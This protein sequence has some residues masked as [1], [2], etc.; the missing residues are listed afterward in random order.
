M[1][2]ARRI[3]FF[4]MDYLDEANRG[5]IHDFLSLGQNKIP[6]IGAGDIYTITRVGAFPDDFAHS[7]NMASCSLWEQS[8]TWPK[9]ADYLSPQLG[10]LSPAAATAMNGTAA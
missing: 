6:T 9:L 10:P 1:I 4:K 7:V 2:K 5:L 3:K 8:G